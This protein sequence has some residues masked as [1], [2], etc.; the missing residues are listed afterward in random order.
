[1]S[2][3]IRKVTSNIAQE[4][5]DMIVPARNW[6]W[7]GYAADVRDEM[8]T[9]HELILFRYDEAIATLRMIQTNSDLYPHVVANDILDEIDQLTTEL[10]ALAG[11]KP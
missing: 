2:E 9:K 1:M 4:L 10:G 5:E 3:R 11:L 8:T 7:D 6:K